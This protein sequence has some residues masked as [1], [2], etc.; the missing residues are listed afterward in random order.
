VHVPPV[1]APGRAISPRRFAVV[2]V[3]DML[4]GDDAAGLHVLSS[5]HALPETPRADLALLDAGLPGFPFEHLRGR[6]GLVL[7]GTLALGALPGTVHVLDAVR[8][9]TLLE[10]RGRGRPSGNVLPFLDALVL[11]GYLPERCAVVALEPAVVVAGPGLSP[12]VRD[13]IPAAAHRT[14]DVCLALLARDPSAAQERPR[15]V[16]MQ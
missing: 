15:P 4:L 11:L 8:A 16:A 3:G 9:H 2:A 10:R 14:I 6:E 1:P 7:L 5:L 12:A 13:A